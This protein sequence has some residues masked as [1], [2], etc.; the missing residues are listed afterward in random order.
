M[1]SLVIALVVMLGR[2]L[3]RSGGG[4]VVLGRFVK[5]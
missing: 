3:M 1:S 2:G 4:F 5:V